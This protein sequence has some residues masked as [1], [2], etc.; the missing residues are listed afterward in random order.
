MLVPTFTSA[1]LR[2]P[3]P[4]TPITHYEVIS[5]QQQNIPDMQTNLSMYTDK[6]RSIKDRTLNI[7]NTKY[8]RQLHIL[9][10]LFLHHINGP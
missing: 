4:P 6:I 2:S 10:P 5:Q 7:M 9:S 1:L 3:T 8:Y